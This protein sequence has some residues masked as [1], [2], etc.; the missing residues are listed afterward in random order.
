MLHTFIY[1]WMLFTFYL[2]ECLFGTPPWAE[3]LIDS[4][5]NE[6]ETIELP[7]IT[8]LNLIWFTSRLLII[9]PVSY[10]NVILNLLSYSKLSY[11]CL[12]MSTFGWE[13]YV[14]GFLSLFNH[15]GFQLLG[16]NEDFIEN[17]FKGQIDFISSN[18]IM[19]FGVVFSRNL[20]MHDS[21]HLHLSKS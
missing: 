3:T 17:K 9:H 2:H 7:D 10:V 18:V 4:T 13:Y 12:S 6:R 15:V 20:E 1:T 8:F 21:F 5:M 19:A 14:V 16:L 11:R